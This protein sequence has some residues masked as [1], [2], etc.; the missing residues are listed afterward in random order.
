MKTCSFRNA[1]PS[2]YNH[3][4]IFCIDSPQA[5]YEMT[6]CRTVSCRFC[7]PISDIITQ[8]RQDNP[9][10]QFSSAQKYRFV[11][12]YEVILNGPVVCAHQ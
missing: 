3:N 5:H 10:V 7:F 4:G 2:L 8:A 9:V 12:G 11:N 6:P 1:Q